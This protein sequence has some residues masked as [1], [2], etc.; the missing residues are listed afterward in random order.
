MP[1]QSS[2]SPVHNAASNSDQDT[3]YALVAPPEGFRNARSNVQRAMKRRGG[4]RQDD[5]AAAAAPRIL[6]SKKSAMAWTT[7]KTNNIINNDHSS[8]TNIN[9][10]Y[11]GRETDAGQDLFKPMLI[12]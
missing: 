9:N 12:S 2:R 1:R 11:H 10:T 7:K 4:K 8:T 3:S 5:A 6:V